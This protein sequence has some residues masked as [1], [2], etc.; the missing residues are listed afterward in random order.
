MRVIRVHPCVSAAVIGGLVLVLAAAL[1]AQAPP[2]DQRRE[3]AHLVATVVP[4]ATP[5]APGARVSLRLD[6]VPKPKMHVYSAEQKDYI[7]ISLTLDPDPSFKAHPVVFP[8]AERFYFK[9]LDETQLVFSKP[10]RI[11]QDI[12]LA[13]AR[14]RAGGG[15]L[16]VTGTLRYQA[17][18]DAVCYRPETVAVTWNLTLK[19]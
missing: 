1:A 2:N 14:G 11:T 12:T 15:T 19:P 8:K 7:P 10:F 5:V 16:R 17:C 6:V 18:D 3:T 13:A 4:V 9:A